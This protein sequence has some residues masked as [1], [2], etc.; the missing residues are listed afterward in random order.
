[1]SALHVGNDSGRDNLASSEFTIH[2]DTIISALCIEAIHYGGEALLNTLLNLFKNN[3]CV[4]SDALPYRGNEYFF[5]KPIYR[6]ENTQLQSNP[7]ERKLYKKLTYVPLS[8][9]EE[10]L[11]VSGNAHFD[12]H[13]ATN[14][15][16]DLAFDDKRQC[17]AVTGKEEASPYFIGSVIFN[18]DCG[19]Y[20]I[21]GY[22]S[23][24]TKIMLEKLLVSLSYSGI[25]G[26]RSAG[27]GKFELGNAINI[28]KIENESM[29]RLEKLLMNK[30]ASLYMTL[31]TSLPMEQEMDEVLSDA[32][33]L[34]CRRGGFVQSANYADS[35][36][37]KKTIYALS[38]GA[39]LRKTYSGTLCNLADGGNH[40]V[41]RCLKPLFVGVSL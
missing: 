29:S 21:V 25:G 4:F 6:K 37:K 17:V 38:S 19:L 11:N 40:P 2:S 31:N 16:Q 26:K 13:R 39:C 12:I 8:M 28:G 3:V 7:E 18:D 35:Q 32:N 22:D 41:Y 20:L 23:S 14:M 15:L 9:F 34:L 30:S 33:F 10:Y 27:L 5:P 24:S 36:L 1:M